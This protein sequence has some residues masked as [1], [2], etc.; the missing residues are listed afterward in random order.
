[1]AS[2]MAHKRT[3][4]AK[5]VA[6]ETGLGKPAPV[7]KIKGPS[8]TERRIRSLENEVNDLKGGQQ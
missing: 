1:M 8:A 2:R 4:A 7:A 5:Q 6:R 3:A